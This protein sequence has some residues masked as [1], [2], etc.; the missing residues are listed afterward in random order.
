MPRPIAH[1]TEE[2]I[3]LAISQVHTIRGREPP[4]RLRGIGRSVHPGRTRR[5]MS[6]SGS[7]AL[8]RRSYK[9]M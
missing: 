3:E 8:G 9:L 2:R 4:R 5:A 7:K 1:A 6:R